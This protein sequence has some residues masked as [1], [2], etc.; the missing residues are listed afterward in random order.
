[1]SFLKRWGMA[2]AL[3]G[4]LAVSPIFAAAKNASFPF[5][6][7]GPF[8]LSDHSGQTVTAADFRGRF[9]LIYFGYTYCH[10]ICP[11]NLQV[12]G[13]TSTIRRS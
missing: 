13:R 8:T 10:D 11:T 7:G 6:I 9:M 3:F 2:A 4:V 12:M 5:Q 1:M